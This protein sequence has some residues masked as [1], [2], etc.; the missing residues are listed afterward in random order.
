MVFKKNSIFI[1]KWYECN[2]SKVRQNVGPMTVMRFFCLVQYSSTVAY[3]GLVVANHSATSTSTITIQLLIPNVDSKTCKK[4]MLSVSGLMH[5]IFYL[6]SCT[7]LRLLTFADAIKLRDHVSQFLDGLD[8]FLKVFAFDEVS[9]L[10]II[11]TIGQLVQVKKRF[12][13][14]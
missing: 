7:A 1:D 3:K 6:L 14:I 12:V 9:Q 2:V 4:N 11:V 13:D 5:T 8:L 10:R